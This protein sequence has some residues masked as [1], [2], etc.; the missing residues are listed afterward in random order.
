LLDFF[1]LSSKD[2]GY[3]GEYENSKTDTAGVSVMVCV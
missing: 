1:F 3:V 2:I